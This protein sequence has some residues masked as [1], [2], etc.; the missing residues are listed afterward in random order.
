MPDG[1]PKFTAAAI[2]AAP[3]FLDREATVDKACHLTAEAAKNG[4]QLIVFPET[5][6]PA[7][8]FWDMGN[9]D[10]WLHLYQNAIEVPSPAIEKLGEAA[11]R[12]GAYVVIGVNERDA[13]TQGS[14]YNSMLYFSPDGTLLG[15][16]RK[17]MPSVSEKMI[18]GMGDGSG[19]HILET[20]LGRLGGLICW[21]HEMTLVKYAMYSRGEQ[22]HA[23][24]WPAWTFQRDH[25]QFGTRQ[26]AYEGKS[27]VIVSCGVLDANA[28]PKNWRGPGRAAGRVADG[29]SAIIAP[30]GSYVAEPVYN[31]ETIIYGDIDL[32]KVALAKREVDVAGHY[33][34][35]DVVRLLFD[36]SPHDPLV[37]PLDGVDAGSPNEPPTP[38]TPTKPKQRRSRSR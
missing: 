3:E 27:F 1:F 7:Y 25:I 6:I 24:V 12:A 19:L 10:G 36:D 34:R 22:V 26:Y 4:A 11:R 8:P 31:E 23:S 29:G 20:P 33:S 14:L 37:G 17:L 32:R 16:H 28:V 38:D 18:W 15:V 2:Q 13:A 21:E 5:W 9:P 30:D 35:P